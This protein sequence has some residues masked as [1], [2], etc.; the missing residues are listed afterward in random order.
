MCLIERH[1]YKTSTQE[2]T[3]RARELIEARY[4]D[5]PVYI[6]GLVMVD[7]R[8]SP[9][10]FWGYDQVTEASGSWR[11]W[12]GWEEFRKISSEASVMR[13]TVEVR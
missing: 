7:E 2:A 11:T 5:K 13:I 6:R 8:F 9:P 1:L 10:K 4:A 12:R 3:E